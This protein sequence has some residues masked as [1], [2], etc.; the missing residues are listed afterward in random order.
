MKVTLSK[1][2]VHAI[3]TCFQCGKDWSAYETARREA[4]QHAKKTGHKVRGEI[5]TAY[6]Y[7]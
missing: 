6:H 5:G 3:F 2:K 1:A 7:N 4:Y